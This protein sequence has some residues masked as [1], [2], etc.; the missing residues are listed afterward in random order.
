MTDEPSLLHI[1]LHASIGW[2]ITVLFHIIPERTKALAF[3]FVFVLA[4]E[5]A[6]FFINVLRLSTLLRITSLGA[7]A[8]V[9][10]AIV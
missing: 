1:A 7:V 4:H 9:Y 10:C 8:T 3:V 5:Q 2:R 6:V